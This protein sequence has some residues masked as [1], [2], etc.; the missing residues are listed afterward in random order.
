M[1]TDT[2]DEIMYCKLGVKFNQSISST[3]LTVNHQRCKPYIINVIAST[4]C[5]IHCNL[6]IISSIIF[7]LL[8]FVLSSYLIWSHAGFLLVFFLTIGW[9]KRLLSLITT[10]DWRSLVIYVNEITCLPLVV[11]CKSYLS[12]MPFFWSLIKCLIVKSDDTPHIIEP[13]HFSSALV[14]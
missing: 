4:W 14:N 3:P 5:N 10:L 6:I 9:M 8:C 2:D 12:M 11:Y 7:R 1:K 13:H